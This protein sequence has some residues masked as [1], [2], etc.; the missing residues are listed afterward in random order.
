[1]NK[2][3]LSRATLGR[4]PMY[5]RYIRAQGDDRISASQMARVLNLGEVMV[6]K[7]LSSV[8]KQGRPKIG[9]PR[10]ELLEMLE[11]TLGT[12]EYVPVVIV[13]TG[14]LGRALMRYQG[15]DEFGLRIVA[16]F[17][18]DARKHCMGECPVLPIGDLADYCGKKGVHV[19]VVAVPTQAAQAVCNQMV[20]AGI[21]A[22]WNFA[23]RRLSVPDGVLV[24]DENLALSLA[25]LCHNEGNGKRR[26]A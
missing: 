26:G 19:G 5:L 4:L 1:M 3:T 21:D 8:C 22:I 24:H 9:Y 17:D 20:E 12:W 14:K 23:P 6:R 10:Q 16:G 11:E 25:H 13:G 7:D 2:S 15:F 18:I